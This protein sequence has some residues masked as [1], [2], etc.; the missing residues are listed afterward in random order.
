MQS[1]AFLARR[2]W[3]LIAFV[4]TSVAAVNGVAAGIAVAL[5]ELSATALEMIV[6]LILAAL[7]IALLTA[8]RSW[9]RVGFR[10][11][12]RL[13]DLRLYWLPLFPVLPAVPAAIVGITGMRFGE[14]L[15]FLILACLIGLVEEVFFRGLILQA[16]A[17]KGLWRS[18]I[19][20][21]VIFGAMHLLNLLFGADLTATLFQASYAVALGFAFAAVTLR[22]CVLWPLI[23]I[24]ALT[25]F[26]GFISAN[27]PVTTNLTFTGILIY[28]LYS[29]FFIVYGIV[30]MR[31]TIRQMQ[32][33]PA[34]QVTGATRD[35]SRNAPGVAA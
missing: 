1:T 11:L 20:S 9:G 3:L 15:Y 25:D 28:G 14:I 27:E 32:G 12:I 21:G 18:A 7:A 19:L 29:V 6:E 2:P 10:A 35:D 33:R 22:T 26:T 34:G 8:L 17:A 30:V 4:V 5:P 16:L 31:S 24:H 13:S 23:V